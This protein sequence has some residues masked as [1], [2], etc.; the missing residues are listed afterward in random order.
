[1]NKN[2]KVTAVK[3]N[4]IIPSK[5]PEVSFVRVESR[6]NEIDDNGWVKETYKAAFIKGSPKA[7]AGLGYSDGQMIGGRINLTETTETPE[8]NAEDAMKLAGDTGV[9][10]TIGGAPI[11]RVMNYSSNEEGQD[12]L[13][14]HDN[15]EEILAAQTELASATEEADLD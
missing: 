4:V 2:V 3:G 5:N 10:C 14:A 9:A 6:T 1:M 8:F 15:K 7:L 13:L 12:T 11:Y